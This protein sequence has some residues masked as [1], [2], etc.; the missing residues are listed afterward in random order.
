MSSRELLAHYLIDWLEESV[1]Q[2][3][4]PMPSG[5]IPLSGVVP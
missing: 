3:I 5:S 4:Q 1:T 2:R